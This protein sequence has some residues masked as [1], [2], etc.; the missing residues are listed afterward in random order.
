MFISGLLNIIVKS[1]RLLFN[2]VLINDADQDKQN[3]W[4]PVY[5]DI[6]KVDVNHTLSHALT[7][8]PAL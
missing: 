7:L 3:I 8:L 6:L 4:F 1:M 5:I 2:E